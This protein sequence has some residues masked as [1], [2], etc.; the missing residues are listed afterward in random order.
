MWT[1]GWLDWAVL[2]SGYVFALAIFRFLGGFPAAG[3]AF[4]SWSQAYSARK[5]KLGSSSS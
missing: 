2:L 1:D 5:T 4:R 3:D